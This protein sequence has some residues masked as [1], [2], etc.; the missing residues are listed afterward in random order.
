MVKMVCMTR[1]NFMWTGL[2]I[3]GL[4]LFLGWIGAVLAAI[5]VI[6]VNEKEVELTSTEQ[7]KH[8]VSN[9]EEER[10]KRDGF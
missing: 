2:G 4:T 9:A 1:D 7:N 8:G 10:L 3:I 6:S 5:Y